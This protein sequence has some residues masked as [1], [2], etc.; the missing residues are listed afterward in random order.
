MPRALRVL[1]MTGGD[2]AENVGAVAKG[3]GYDLG[4]D[5]GERGKIPDPGAGHR[6]PGD[7]PPPPAAVPL[8]VAGEVLLRGKEVSEMAENAYLNGKLQTRATAEIKAV[9]QKPAPEGKVVKHTGS[10]LRD[11]KG[12]GK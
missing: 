6:A 5:A 11:G 1:A 7:T 12:N 8:P 4:R 2:R 3:W 10:D 9:N